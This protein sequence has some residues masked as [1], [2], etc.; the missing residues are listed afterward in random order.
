MSSGPPAP[1]QRARDLRRAA[2]GTAGA[3]IAA[4]AVTALVFG[5][6]VAPTHPDGCEIG[7][8]D[9]LYGDLVVPLHLAAF[10]VIAG[11]VWEITRRRGPSP[12]VRRAT[13]GGLATLTAIVLAGLVVDDVVG[14]AAFAGAVAGLLVGPLILLALVVHVVL[15]WRRER[16]PDRRWEHMARMAQVFA[17]LALT[18]ALPLSF[19]GSWLNGAGI[20]CF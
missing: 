16:D 2:V 20:F 1:Y 10:V 13:I 15:S 7:L 8:W 19:A 9:G 11:A 5:V 4:L 12:R 3:C 6:L 18:L 14:W 17:W